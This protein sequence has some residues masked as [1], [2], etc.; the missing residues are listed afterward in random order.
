MTD[1][2]TISDFWVF[3]I[4]Q[5]MGLMYIDQDFFHFLSIFFAYFNFMYRYF[6]KMAKNEENGICLSRGL[7]LPKNSSQQFQTR[8]PSFKYQCH[9]TS[10]KPLF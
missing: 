3:V 10:R 4:N 7:N 6:Q 5:K 1:Q 2:V 8:K 9:Q